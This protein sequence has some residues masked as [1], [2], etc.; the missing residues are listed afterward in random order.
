MAAERIM[1]VKMNPCSRAKMPWIQVSEARKAWTSASENGGP[2]GRPMPA[3][4]RPFFAI[5][6]PQ[7]ATPGSRPTTT[8]GA[9][10]R[11]VAW[12]ACAVIT[13]PIHST[14]AM[15]ASIGTAQAMQA[16]VPVSPTSAKNTPF[17]TE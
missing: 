14:I 15:P 8:A 12:N 13:R 4:R 11:G 16:S 2:P 9:C 1:A 5:S 3:A 10:S 17:R 7:A 6:A